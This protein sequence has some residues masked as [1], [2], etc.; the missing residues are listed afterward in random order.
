MNDRTGIHLSCADVE[1]NPNPNE[2]AVLVWVN[3]DEMEAMLIEERPPEQAIAPWFPAASLLAS[4]NAL[5]W[6]A[7][8]NDQQALAELADE[9]IHDMGDG[10]QHATG[11]RRCRL[12]NLHHGSQAAIE[13]RIESAFQPHVMSASVMP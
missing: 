5:R 4:C 13:S 12:V 2:V 6:W 3:H 9:Q 7:S 10:H 8:F 11:C 1:I